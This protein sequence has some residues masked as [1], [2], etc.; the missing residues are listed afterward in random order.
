M[1]FQAHRPTL[2]RWAATKGDDGLAQYR[3]EKNVASIDG[4]LTHLTSHSVPGAAAV[5]RRKGVLTD[6]AD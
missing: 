6:P 2:Q 4:L 1:E 3:A 5:A